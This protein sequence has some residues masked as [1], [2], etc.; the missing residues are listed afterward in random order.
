MLTEEK[1]KE[2]EHA[3]AFFQFNG[4]GELQH[5]EL[6]SLTSE[7]KNKEKEQAAELFSFNGNGGVQY[8]LVQEARH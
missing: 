6:T 8:E 5:E 2:Q 4:D 1:N 7:A 3:T